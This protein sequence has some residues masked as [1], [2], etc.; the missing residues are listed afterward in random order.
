MIA[1]NLFEKVLMEPARR[2]KADNLYVV[3]GYATPGLIDRHFSALE[4][5]SLRLK[6]SVI[7]GMSNSSGVPLPSHKGFLD[8]MLNRYKNKLTCAYIIGGRR[9][10]HSKVYIWTRNKKPLEAFA[11]SAN[12]TQAAFGKRQREILTHTDAEIAFKYWKTINKDAMLCTGPDVEGQITFYKPTMPENKEDTVQL[13]LLNS[14]GEVPSRSGLNWGKGQDATPIRL[15][16]LSPSTFINVD[17]FL[18][19]ENILLFRQMMDK[20]LFAL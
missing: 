6:I 4:K 9:P 14:K 1:D 16:F 18:H 8:L 12:Y 7:F 13:S 17:F 15:T 20:I 11:G 5:E 2:L 19:R 10:V 3:S